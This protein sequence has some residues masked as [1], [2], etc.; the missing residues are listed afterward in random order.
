MNKKLL[1]ASLFVIATYNLT[2][3]NTESD[4]VYHTPDDHSACISALEYAEMLQQSNENASRLNLNGKIQKKS[5]AL[6]P[7]DWPVKKAD[8]FNDCDYYIITKHVDHDK[9]TGIKDYNCGARTY[10]G[11]RGTDITLWPYPF[12]KIDHNQVEVVAAKT[13]VIVNKAD[14]FFDKKCVGSDNSGGGNYV[15]L[16]H[17]DGSRTL[18]Y[19]MK[20][21]SV[22]TKAIGATIL[23]G[24]YIGVVASSGSSN[25]PHLHFEV[26]ADNKATLVDPFYGTC[27]TLN[28]TSLWTTQKPYLDPTISKVSIHNAKPTS[29]ACPE[30]EVLN[31]KYTFVPEDYEALFYIHKRDEEIDVPVYLRIKNPNGSVFNSW[32][33]KGTTTWN[34]ITRSWLKT[35]PTQPGI[36]TFEAELHGK[37]CSTPFEI[38]A[39]LAT[40]SFEKNQNRL[41]P[42]PA[43]NILTI[44]WNSNEPEPLF[45][46]NQLGQI[47]IQKSK[48]NESKTTIDIS[49][50][51]PGLYL[52]QLGNETHKFIKE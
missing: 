19:H 32:E 28:A 26:W 33:S 51:S 41:Y 27:N 2:A 18:Y 1:F 46:K 35:L 48:I 30:T 22:T 9:T 10:D 25:I 40:N 36:Y 24:E 43:Q 15:M 11:H 7:L 44:D 23:K 29:P 12:Y 38:V 5:T 31:E 34:G 37:V 20:K 6:E 45:I 49:G 21:N 42:N 4:I 3:Q 39:T 14:G 50:L 13:G 8:G 16:Q 47:V 17:S 52:V